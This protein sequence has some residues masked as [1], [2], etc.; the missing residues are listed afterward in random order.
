M[1]LSVAYNVFLLQHMYSFKMVKLILKYS[2]KFSLFHTVTLL[3]MAT[4]R[5]NFKS[6]LSVYYDFTTTEFCYGQS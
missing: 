3:I 6:F 1:L 2:T 5:L 4:K